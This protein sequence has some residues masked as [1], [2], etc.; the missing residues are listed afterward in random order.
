MQFAASQE[1]AVVC[2]TSATSVPVAYVDIIA[3]L[4]STTIIGIQKHSLGVAV[5]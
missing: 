1:E 5:Q 3:Q 4:A 2:A